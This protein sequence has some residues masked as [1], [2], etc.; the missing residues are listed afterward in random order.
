MAARP[1]DVRGFARSGRFNAVN[2]LLPKFKSHCAKKSLYI[3]I[4]RPMQNG[5]LKNGNSCQIVFSVI[6]ERIIHGPSGT[7]LYGNLCVATR[8]RYRSM[9]T[10]KNVKSIIL[11]KDN[12][13]ATIPAFLSWLC[14]A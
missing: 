7:Q 4:H 12:R 9:H 10:C 13:S 14:Q 2:S 1:G 5:P 6:L 8:S 11:A 3:V